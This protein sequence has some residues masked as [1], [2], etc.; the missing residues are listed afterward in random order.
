MFD[1]LPR[2]L[3]GNANLARRCRFAHLAIAAVVGDD[4]WT[5]RIGGDAVAVDRGR[6]AA[7]DLTFSAPA[8]TWAA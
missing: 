6:T 1:A 4:V 2:A 5:V 8:S 3:D 7:A